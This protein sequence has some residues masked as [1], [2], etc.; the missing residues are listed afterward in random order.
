MNDE[1]FAKLMNVLQEI[2]CG[3]IDVEN[4]IEDHAKKITD[5]LDNLFD[6]SI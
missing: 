1:Q 3:L 6:E 4:A 5:K 2:R